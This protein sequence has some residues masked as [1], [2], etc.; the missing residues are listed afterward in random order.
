MVETDWREILNYSQKE[1]KR[2]DKEKL[3]ESLS[4]MEA[5]DIELNFSDLKTLF[6]LAQDILKFKNE[7]V[8]NLLGQL[9][10]LKRKYD[11]AKGKV[12]VMDSPSK[13]SDILET[14]S[15]QEDLIKANK[16]ILEQLYSEI[17]TLE[18]RK[19]EIEKHTSKADLDSESSRDALSEMGAIAELE[20]EILKKNKHIRKLLSD[21]K[22]LE[23]ENTNLKQ[24][25]SVF[26]EK[27]KESVQIID[28]LTE[29][30]FTINSECAQLKAALGKCENDKTQ[31]ILETE[32]LNRKLNEKKSKQDIIQDDVKL[33]LQHLKE[34]IKLHKTEISRLS[35]ENM[36]Q[37]EEISRLL[38]DSSFYTQYKD[39]EVKIKELQNKLSEAASHMVESAELITVLKAENNKLKRAVPVNSEQKNV[40]KPVNNE[41]EIIRS[42]EKKN[43][44][45]K[46]DLQGA[47]EMIALREK[48]LTDITTQLQILQQDEGI[49]SLI[50]GL[51]NK[52]RELKMKDVGIKSLVQ[53]VNNLHQLVSEL[54]IENEIMRQKLNIPTNEKIATEGF[55]RDYRVLKQQNVNW[56]KEIRKN[57]NKITVLEME[58]YIKSQ[59]I[60]KL[61]EFLRS[62]GFTDDKIK[63]VM[64]EETDTIELN[65][66]E[67]QKEADENKKE[68][69]ENDI[70]NKNGESLDVKSILEENEGL[71]N[72]LTEILNYLKDN[73][74]TSSGVLTLEC[75]S[76]DTLLESMEARRAAGWF[77]PHMKTILEL[78]AALGG[79]D[80]LLTALHESRRETFDVMNQLSQESKKCLE[81]ENELTKIKTTVQKEKESSVDEHSLD[82]SD[83][84]FGPWILDGAYNNIDF[85]DKDKLQNIISKGDTI[86]ERNVKH[87]LLYFKSKFKTLYEKLTSLSINVAEAKNNWSIQEEHYKAQ[88]I[89][90]KSQ[91]CES[92]DEDLSE[93]SPGI[94]NENNQFVTQAKYNYL[95]ENYKNI[96]TLYENLR[97]EL[98]EEKKETLFLASDYEE[99]LQKI[100]IA[101]TELTGKLRKSIPIELFF[102]QNAT[103][104]D[105]HLKYRNFL[106][107]DTSTHIKTSDF[108]TQMK[109][110]KIEIINNFKDYINEGG[111]VKDELQKQLEKSINQNQ[112]VELSNQLQD[113]TKDIENLNKKVYEL[114]KTHNELMNKMSYSLTNEEINF[115]KESLQNATIE[116]NALKEQCREL[117]KELDKTYMKLQAY[118]H[119]DLSIQKEV[120]MLRH[121]IVDLQVPGQSTAAIS[122]LNNEI[123][124]AHLQNVENLQ[125]IET[126]KL[127]LNKERQLRI[128]AEEMLEKQQKVLQVYVVRN[129]VKF[130]NMFEV[131]ESLRQQYQGVLPLL[132]IESFMNSVDYMQEKTRDL[133]EKLNEV[134]ELRLGLM[135]KHSVYDQIINLSKC[136]EEQDFCPHKIKHLMMEKRNEM[137]LEHNKKKIEILEQSRSTLVNRCNNLEKNLLLIN[138]GF[139]PAKQKQIVENKTSSNSQNNDSLEVEEIHSDTDSS[140][141]GDETYTLRIIPPK[142]NEYI[143]KSTQAQ[144]IEMKNVQIQTVAYNNK[145]EHKEVQL[146]E[147]E[148]IKELKK[149]LDMITEDNYKREKELREVM[150]SYKEQAHEITK[151]NHLN[152]AL[153]KDKIELQEKIQTLINTN[154]HKDKLYETLQTNNESLK[155]QLNEYKNNNISQARWQSEAKEE[156][157]SL[158]LNMKQIENSKNKIIEEY[159]ELIN[160][161]RQEYGKLINDLQFKL[162]ALQAQLDQRSD[163]NTINEVNIKGTSEK[164]ETNI[165]E[166]EDKCFK[167]NCNLDTCESELKTCRSELERWKNLASERLTKMEQLSSQLQERHNQEVDSYKAENQHWLSQLNET[168]RE[169][170]EL[171]TRLTEQKTAHLKQLAEKDAHIEHLRA[172]INNLKTQIVNMQTM[173]SIN[174]PSFDLSAI[175]EVEEV[176]DAISHQDSDMLELKFESTGNLTDL[177]D[178]LKKF[179]ASSTAIWQEP[180]IDRLRREKQLM[181]KQ[182][183]LL[184][185]QIKALAGRERRARL[186]AQNLKNQVF[187]ISTSGQK[188]PSAESAVL[189]NKIA[190]LQAQLTSARRDANSTVALWDKWKRAQQASERW[191]ARY[192]EKCQ[193]ILKL[194]SS[195]NLAKSAISRLEKEKR[196]LLSRL[197]ET[198]NEKQL[199]IEKQNEESSEK[200]SVDRVRHEYYDNPPHLLTKSLL[201]RVEAQQRRIVALEI[202]EKGNEPLVSEYEKSLAEITSLKGQVLKL[203]SALLEAQIKSPLRSNQDSKPE[204]EYWKSYCEMLKEENMQLTLKLNTIESAPVHHQ[205]V[206]DL[207]QTVLTLRGLVSKLQADQKSTIS[208]HKRSDS[209]PTSGQS[210]V[211]RNRNQIES[212][213]TEIM[214]LKRSIHEKDLLLEKSKE[215]L[216]I[217]AEREEDLLRENTI[218]RHR[219]EELSESRGFL[220][221]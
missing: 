210:N 100:M 124:L 61:I 104:N 195:L 63:E 169:H 211:D 164:L 126:L 165:T 75:P 74:T 107:R 163:T 94:V 88:I 191:Q 179:P 62:S 149:E 202:A 93:P 97:N 11:K 118:S 52:K 86:Y 156:N 135:S 32:N 206:N 99:R 95:E 190:T 142:S 166:L 119:N 16:E 115:M 82:F 154:M 22:T 189:Q 157:R 66:E 187:R 217:A 4:W 47:N 180:L 14:I 55:L 26:K 45:L 158:I 175:V 148:R 37:K 81:L 141:K 9:D 161:E 170:M 137:E 5:D 196:I 42:L 89:N 85:L 31:Y 162:R 54:Q 56:S 121:Q 182:N 87:S 83:G 120:N 50:T 197:S 15:H 127:T 134:E 18:N 19:E 219:L 64:V 117:K 36:N 176:S 12:V 72:S 7:Q 57:A 59:K 98:L 96:R 185:K 207:E 174:D 111:N 46:F 212:Y 39:Q 69:Q 152:N 146:D 27:L 193:E 173:I 51:K 186:D 30:L 71:R 38:N 92:V 128:D 67:E 181:G 25:L 1:L 90:L 144:P 138:R 221:A 153:N 199:A 178:D 184:R 109:A 21:V 60:S 44:K 17:T 35:A 76:L 3:C 192:D 155:R 49:K 13:D 160:N 84:E 8:N 150:L 110:Q 136:L 105:F 91:I 200:S 34:T 125:R 198:K 28:N 65:K 143:T 140:K 116:N 133:N 43:A 167:L 215:M 220:S 112:I 53:E 172:I 73:S 204:L 129:G 70:I 101:N 151:L 102:E 216:K 209:R 79:R 218:L 80:A 10:T 6:R 208:G 201:E 123:L 103:L 205:R 130:R 159:K 145:K 177:Q 203:E 168:Q 106:A 113:K 40:T 147:D 23:E 108:L 183:A 48:E 188:V 68:L 78:R 41:N 24:K 213:R 194:E 29:Q 20:N 139:I 131:N 2:S 171:R 132:S 214:N 122:R 77:A 58:N 33:K 114:E